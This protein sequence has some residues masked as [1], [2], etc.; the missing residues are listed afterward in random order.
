[1]K[2]LQLDTQ[3]IT[4]HPLLLLVNAAIESKIKYSI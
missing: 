4:F 1:V 3:K 2:T